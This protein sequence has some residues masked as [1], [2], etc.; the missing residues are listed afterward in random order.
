MFTVKKEKIGKHLGDLIVKKFGS[1]RQFCIRILELRDGEANPNDIQL[2]QNRVSHIINGNNW[3]QIEDLPIFSDL[4]EVSIEEIVSGGSITKPVSDRVTNYSMAASTDPV[5]WEKHVNRE[6]K[7]ILNPDEYNKTIIDYALEFGNY[8][9]LK[10]LL[11]NKYIWF[12]DENKEYWGNFGAGTNISRREPG[13]YDLLDLRMKQEDDLR[14]RMIALA[15]KNNDYDMLDSL[16]AREFP[17]LHRLAKFPSVIGEDTP[18][19]NNIEELIDSITSSDSKVI[20]YFFSEFK[21]DS[22]NK[23]I[24]NFFVFPY[25][26][27]ILDSLISSGKKNTNQFLKE[28]IKHNQKV[29]VKLGKLTTGNIKES[30]EYYKA[31]GIELRPPAIE[32]IKREVCF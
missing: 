1:Q 26:G 17:Y 31:M 23:S 8:P 9:F 4:L 18:E 27:M 24:E 5:E 19:P 28:A 7:L 3:I 10:Y 15:L 2:M 16:K 6:D 12:T 32:E 14:T 29:Q 13:S 22:P 21:I 11:S 25:V 30:K 20:S